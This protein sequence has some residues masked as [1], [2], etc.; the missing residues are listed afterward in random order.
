MPP[1]IFSPFT[2]QLL[3]SSSLYEFLPLLLSPLSCSAPETFYIYITLHSL[4]WWERCVPVSLDTVLLL[5]PGE[6]ETRRTHTHSPVSTIS[7]HADAHT[8]NLFSICLSVPV[9]AL[10]H[11][12]SNEN[13][14][15]IFFNSKCPSQPLRIMWNESRVGPDS[16]PLIQLI[17]PPRAFET[18]PLIVS[19]AL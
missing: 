6:E 9:S 7:S 14:Q 18:I 16:S 11:T 19:G 8:H 12:A 13:M 15:P 5:P 17:W 3:H 4:R 1:H 2:L 10:T